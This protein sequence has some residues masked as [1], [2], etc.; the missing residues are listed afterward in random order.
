[1]LHHT[2]DIL[3]NNIDKRK[4]PGGDGNLIF[5]SVIAVVNHIDKRKV[6]GGD[7]NK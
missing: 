3:S 5:Y 7:G 1:M 2:I 4:V 6:P